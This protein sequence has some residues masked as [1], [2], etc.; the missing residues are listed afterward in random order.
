RKRKR[1]Y[2]LRT[3]RELCDSYIK[4]P[5]TTLSESIV[6][7]TKEGRTGQSGRGGAQHR[8][9]G[10]VHRWRSSIGGAHLPECS[11]MRNA[12]VT[13]PRPKPGD[14]GP[15]PSYPFGRAYAL[16]LARRYPDPDS[17]LSCSS[18]LR[19]HFV[20]SGKREG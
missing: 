9:A 13:T 12:E 4:V 5:E 1:T 15:P 20:G 10:S 3:A 18:F 6:E 19:Y 14:R 17:E 8:G 7:Y 2:S 11:D 16:T